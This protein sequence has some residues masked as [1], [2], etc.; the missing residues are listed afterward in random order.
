MPSHQLVEGRAG[1]DVSFRMLKKIRVHDGTLS[2]ARI[3]IDATTRVTMSLAVPGICPARLR[4]CCRAHVGERGR[5]RCSTGTPGA[6]GSW[7]TFGWGPPG[8]MSSYPSCWL[9]S[10]ATT[11]RD[12]WLDAASTP[13]ALLLRHPAPSTPDDGATRYRRPR[14]RALGADRGEPRD[15]RDRRA[16]L[17]TAV[18]MARRRP[19]RPLETG[20]R[21]PM[22][23]VER[24]TPSV[25]LLGRLGRVRVVLAC[26]PAAGGRLVECRQAL[27]PSPGSRL[28]WQYAPEA[29]QEYDQPASCPG[30]RHSGVMACL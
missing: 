1:R 18:S 13:T 19:S 3:I 30:S 29:E 27:K 11:K 5:L 9:G 21:S 14:P 26:R 12:G 2:P 28:I 10:A 8:R 16:A 23:T 15:L 22:I 4:P 25:L 20:G 7:G 6:T 17:T 24:P